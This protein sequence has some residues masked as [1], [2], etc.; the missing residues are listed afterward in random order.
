MHLLKDRQLAD[1][2]LIPVD[3]KMYSPNVSAADTEVQPRSESFFPTLP[4]LGSLMEGAASAATGIG[5]LFRS[6]G[7][8]SSGSDAPVPSPAAQEKLP[9]RRKE[10]R[11]PPWKT[12]SAR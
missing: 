9:R 11:L 5:S 7:S 2:A 8:P 12:P 3:V 4:V 1:S 10:K 6:N